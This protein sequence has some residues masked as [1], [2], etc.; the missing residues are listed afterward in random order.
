M[1]VGGDPRHAAVVE[2][3][4]RRNEL[5]SSAPSLR[6]TRRSPSHAASPAGVA[7]NS[8]GRSRPVLLLEEHVERR[9]ARAP[10]ARSWP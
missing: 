7:A 5:T 9:R 8:V 1:R 2:R 6:R 3:G 4:P 10:S